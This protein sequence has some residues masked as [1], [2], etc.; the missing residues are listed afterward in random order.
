VSS[1]ANGAPL[2]QLRTQT[3]DY[4]EGLIE[5]FVAYDAQ[6]RMTYMN[7]AAERI[8][9]RRRDEVLGQ[10]WHEAFPHAIGNALDLMYQRVMRDR[11]AERLEMFYPHYGHWMEVSAAPVRTGGVAVYFRDISPRK[12]AE[13]ALREADRR[14]DEFLATLGH[15]LRN[16]LAPIRNGLELLRLAEPG[17]DTAAHAQAMMERQTA[18]LVRLV[19]DLLE[20][21]RISTGK[22]EL[23]PETVELAAVLG[24]AIETS[25]PLIDARGHELKV[26]LPGEV[27]RLRGDPVRLAQVVSNLLNNAARYTEG[28]GR[29]T[30]GA[31]R[32]EGFAVLS[33]RD[34]GAGI[35]PDVLPHIFDMFMQAGRTAHSQGGLGIGLTLARRLLDL[36]GGRIDAFSAGPG[37]GS[38]FVVRL[39]LLSWGASAAPRA[40]AVRRRPRD[41]EASRK[42][43]VV[44]DNV[45]AAS[46][47]GMVLRHLG[48]QV[49]V[50]HDGAAALEAV[51]TAPPDVVL[52]D[53]SMP[54]MDGLEVARRMRAGVL[55]APL[56]IVAVSGLGQEE[57]RRRAR[58]AGFDDHVVKPVAVDRLPAIL[59]L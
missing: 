23:R 42:V 54:G 53:I 29:I 14:K 10:T 17:S 52:L 31:W 33:V 56:R 7:A 27:L 59:G 36:H 40:D 24:S 11:S 49:R 20:I 16:P 9:K 38:E 6:W 28:R 3:A 15:E 35:E 46:S 51:A 4:L 45:D 48:H 58:E 8:L 18:H 37:K 12:R 41:A 43:L 2:D 32:E 55:S 25:R 13:E 19:D 26:E 44:D 30:L 34:N 39:P 50:V 47:L 57:D 22:L 5:G 21:S 1:L